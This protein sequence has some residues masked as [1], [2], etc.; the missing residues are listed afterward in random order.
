M[1]RPKAYSPCFIQGIF[2]QTGQVE[3]FKMGISGMSHRAGPRGRMRMCILIKA[4]LPYLTH[5]DKGLQVDRSGS[6]T[7]GSSMHRSRSLGGCMCASP[8]L[9]WTDFSSSRFTRTDMPLSVTLQFSTPL[10]N[11]ISSWPAS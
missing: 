1:D 11:S 3:D 2:T 4:K 8:M 5:A 10:V 6:D 7:M 9:T